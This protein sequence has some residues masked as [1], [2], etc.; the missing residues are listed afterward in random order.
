MEG[1]K[2]SSFE[3]GSPSKSQVPEC[4]GCMALPEWRSAL[5]LKT[6]LK[7]SENG[8]SCCEILFRAIR[9][10]QRQQDFGNDDVVS[11]IAYWPRLAIRALESHMLEFLVDDGGCL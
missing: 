10:L 3:K 11:I 5:D 1:S 7:Q 6:I 9:W 4:P 2:E 8:C